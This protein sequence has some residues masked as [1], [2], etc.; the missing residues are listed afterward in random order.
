MAPIAI[1]MASSGTD[2]TTQVQRFGAAAPAVVTA[3]L[4]G[5]RTGVL[6]ALRQEIGRA[7]P[8]SRRM[9]NLI[10]AKVYPLREDD[11]PPTLWIHPRAGSARRIL[12]AHRG[13]QIV[14]TRQGGALAIP[15]DKVPLRHHMSGRLSPDEVA[16]HFGERLALMPARP[17]SKAWGYLVL[18]RSAVHGTPVLHGWPR[19]PTW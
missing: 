13:V 1:S 7:F 10:T 5:V 18:R 8:R 16:R 15:T 14:P 4:E 12:A 17:G 6:T 19:R 11:A 2:W 3:A 9:P